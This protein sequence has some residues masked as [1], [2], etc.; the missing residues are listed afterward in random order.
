MQQAQQ[1][2]QLNDLF[3]QVPEATLENNQN[4]NNAQP[5]NNNGGDNS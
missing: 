1:Q 4:N 2:Q 3:T 5:S